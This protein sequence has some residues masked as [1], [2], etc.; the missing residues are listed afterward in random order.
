MA[1]ADLQTIRSGIAT[2]LKTLDGIDQVYLYEPSST[3]GGCAA[4]V[5][6]PEP[7]SLL[8]TYGKGQLDLT[9]PVTLVA[10]DF[11][12]KT[13]WVRM[14]GWVLSS[15]GVWQAFAADSTLGGAV[16]QAVATEVRGIGA[17]EFGG[18]ERLAA[19]VSVRVLIRRDN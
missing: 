15:A 5:G 1:A 18:T 3:T 17:R 8:G 19:E 6:T 9:I 2:V 16:N 12:E 14:D 7:F 13:A 11:T 10:G 4:L